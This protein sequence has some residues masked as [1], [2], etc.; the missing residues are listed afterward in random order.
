MR[1]L[2]LIGLLW[3]TIGYCDAQPS[4]RDTLGSV[5]ILKIT[6]LALFD[7][8]NTIQGGIELPLHNPAWAV[9]QE[10]GYGHSAFNL[11][12]TERELYP[13]R[14]TW[15]F[16]TQLR[17][18]FLRNNQRSP[19]IAGEYLLKK[20]SEERFQAVGIDCTGDPFNRQCAYFQNRETHL[21]RIVNAFHLK[22]GGQFAIGERFYLDIY[23]GFGLRGLNVRYLGLDANE[24]AQPANNFFS[25][26]TNRPGTYGPTGSGSF[27]VHFGYQLGQ[28]VGRRNE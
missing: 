8:D 3:M 9:Q 14:E 26:R 2:F 23:M 27:G 4:Q 1:S 15:R 7:I 22:F 12:Q 25:L 17:Y 6:P 28:K 24:S 19:Y 21:S 10:F 11:W 5:I 13:D 16:R 18:Y 20:N